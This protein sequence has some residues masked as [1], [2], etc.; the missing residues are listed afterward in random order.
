MTRGVPHVLR[1]LKLPLAVALLCLAAGAGCSTRTPPEHPEESARLRPADADACL[2][3]PRPETVQGLPLYDGQTQRI[4]PLILGERVTWASGPRTITAWVGIDAFDVFEDLDFVALPT[5]AGD[6]RL[7]ATRVQPDL[8]V[9][10]R[11]TGFREPCDLVYV[12]TTGMAVD[13]A[14]RV[15]TRL[16]V[17]QGTSD[18]LLE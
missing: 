13:V 6:P 17:R 16:V 12:S 18:E 3:V 9:A 5:I 15:S 11:E 7:W 8:F 2:I 10:A 1:A 14:T 4:S